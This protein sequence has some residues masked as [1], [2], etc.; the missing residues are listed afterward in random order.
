GDAG[1]A[2]ALTLTASRR[3]PLRHR[4]METMPP[5]GPFWTPI[6]GPFS[7]PIDTQAAVASVNAQS[8]P[9]EAPVGLDYFRCCSRAR[10]RPARVGDVPDGCTISG[11]LAE[12]L[13]EG[14]PP[15]I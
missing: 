9:G 13:M 7:T 15:Q 11:V 5:V 6:P 2:A 12:G 10:Y 8:R 3:R 14:G 1:D 4:S